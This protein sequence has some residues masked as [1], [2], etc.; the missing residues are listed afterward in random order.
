VGNP[1]LVP[2]LLTLMQHLAKLPPGLFSTYSERI[3]CGLL[4]LAKDTN[5]PHG[6]LTAIFTL[7]QRISDYPGGTSACTAGLEVLSW[8]LTDDQELSRL[9]SLQQF[10]QLLTTLKAF[11]M[12]NST[13]ASAAALGHL[14]SLVPQLAH[15]ARCLPQATHDQWQSLWVPT[16]HALA[17]IA[18]DGS[19]K[20]SAQAFVYLQ[21][22]LLERGTELSLPWDQLA[23]PVWKECLEQVL[24]PL[25]QRHH[26]AKAANP[27]PNGQP[28]EPV[29]PATGS[30]GEL[31]VEVAAA[32]QASA[33][34][35]V[36]RVVMTH[37][38]DWL[39]SSPEG[40]PLLF[41]RL[42]HILASEAAALSDSREALAES[43]KNLLLVISMDPLFQEHPSPQH[44]QTLLEA[45]WG[46]VDPE[47]PELHREVL[48]ILGPPEP[49]EP[50][51]VPTGGSE[52]PTE[53]AAGY[54]TNGS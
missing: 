1:E 16:L 54:P 11:A 49:E 10:T 48:E 7:L 53:A 35:L 30:V 52:G 20:S 17:D 40:F 23:F 39:Q 51:P 47:L 14:S 34:Q 46:I 3:A 24:F 2:T 18:R 41:L 29:S 45:A 37:L 44:G 19:Q 8:W 9:L 26:A 32:R 4:L 33:A 38:H 50:V 13:N 21:R 27:V 22:L 28:Q 31:P 6:G 25:L 15:G 43:M 42:L 36:C 5:L 12:Q